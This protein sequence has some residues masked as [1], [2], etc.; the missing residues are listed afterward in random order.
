M[1]FLWQRQK[2]R[3]TL[4]FNG[5]RVLGDLRLRMDGGC[6]EGGYYTPAKTIPHK[7]G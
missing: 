3:K 2:A 5:M 4:A 1:L 6:L 7:S